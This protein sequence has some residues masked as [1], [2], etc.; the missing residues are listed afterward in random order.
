MVVILRQS[1]GGSQLETCVSGLNVIL[2]K[3][4]SA[5]LNTESNKCCKLGECQRVTPN[6][7]NR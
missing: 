1:E 2:F 7:N 3:Q 5:V 4:T 6:F